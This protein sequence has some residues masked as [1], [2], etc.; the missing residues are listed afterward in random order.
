MSVGFPLVFG[1]E[2]DFSLTGQESPHRGKVFRIRVSLLCLRWL[3][4]D[5]YYVGIAISKILIFEKLLFIIIGKGARRGCDFCL[6]LFGRGSLSVGFSFWVECLS[7]GGG[8][9]SRAA[10][11]AD[12]F[13]ALFGEEEEG[14]A[15][16]AE[17]FAK[18]SG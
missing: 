10:N 13:R 14:T 9:F 15:F 6:I 4:Q 7:A 17:G 3:L 2:K 16:I 18:F 12:G 8:C 11:G 1:F 5:V